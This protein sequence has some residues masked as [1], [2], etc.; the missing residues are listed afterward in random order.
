MKIPFHHQEHKNQFKLIDE[1][2]YPKGF[3]EKVY[4]IDEL[5]LEENKTASIKE[6]ALAFVPKQTKNIADLKSVS[7]D[8]KK[9]YVKVKNN[10]S[11]HNI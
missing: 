5:K 11:G 10:T 8:V 3:T 7:D 4:E 2:Y 9:E 1:I 6:S